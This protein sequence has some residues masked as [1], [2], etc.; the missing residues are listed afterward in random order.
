MRG[1]LGLAGA[2][3]IAGTMLSAGTASA[4]TC[5]Q[6]GTGNFTEVGTTI[7]EGVCY[8]AYTDSVYNDWS[9][10]QAFAVSLG[11]NL[12]TIVDQTQYNAVAALLA[13]LPADFSPSTTTPG[14]DYSGAW[15]GL[16][17]AVNNGFIAAQVSDLKWVDGNAST[18]VRSTNDLWQGNAGPGS[19]ISN[20]NPSGCSSA[21]TCRD[22]YTLMDGAG[23]LDTAAAFSTDNPSLMIGAIVESLATPLPAALPLFAGGLGA[24]GLLGGW[25]RKRKAAAIVAA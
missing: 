12:G 10:A 23:G 24:F 16:R 15:I 21:G 11:G 17:T 13:S 9:V 6:A 14:K 25:R 1:L 3:A 4:A 7:S 19:A 20:N 5:G 2:A 22:V 8:T 18:F